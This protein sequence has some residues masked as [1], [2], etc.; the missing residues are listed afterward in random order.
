MSCLTNFLARLVEPKSS[1]ITLEIPYFCK[2]VY[3]YSQYKAMTYFF[4]TSVN[5]SVNNILTEYSGISSA[6]R[7]SVIIP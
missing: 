5:G 3:L 4:L 7:G 6:N 2:V 1:Q